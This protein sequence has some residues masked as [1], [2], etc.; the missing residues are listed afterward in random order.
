MNLLELWM[1]EPP[2]SYILP[3]ISTVASLPPTS[4]FSKTVTSASVSWARKYAA[5]VPPIPEDQ[6][7]GSLQTTSFIPAPIIP[8]F[9]FLAVLRGTM[10]RYKY[11]LHLEGNI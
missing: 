7:L 4:S 6:I 10:R 1:M 2:D 9:S 5:E 3:S 8:T 11:I